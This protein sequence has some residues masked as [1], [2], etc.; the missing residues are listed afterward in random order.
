MTFGLKLMTF[1]ELKGFMEL[2]GLGRYEV[3][4]LDGKSLI[5]IKIRE[6]QGSVSRI[7]Q[8]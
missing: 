2:H 5:P 4:F 6:G 8:Q 7:F 1:E 3:H